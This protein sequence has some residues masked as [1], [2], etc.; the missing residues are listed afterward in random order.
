M[1]TLLLT[2][3]AVTVA[4]L[5]LAQS[6]P[7]RFNVPFAFHVGG[8]QLPAGEYSVDGQQHVG[9]ILVSPVGHD[10]GGAFVFTNAIGNSHGLAP[11]T[12]AL[13]FNKYGDSDFF[14]SQAWSSNWPSGLEALKS[15]AE[16][17][18]VSGKLTAHLKPVN[19]SV[20]ASLK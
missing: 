14:L 15:R 17:A 11:A 2:T 12:A 6:A 5:S 3:L 10:G 18:Y 19:V 1:K 16:R 9:A 13:V 7:Q 20:V 8:K 4:G